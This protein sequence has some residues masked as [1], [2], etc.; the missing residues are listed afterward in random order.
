MRLPPRTPEH[1]GEVGALAEVDLVQPPQLAPGTDGDVGALLLLEQRLVD[2]L[3]SGQLLPATLKREEEE[4]AVR[5]LLGTGY[6]HHAHLLPGTPHA[7][8]EH[9]VELVRVGGTG[10]AFPLFGYQAR[11]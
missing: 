8:V 5:W 11:H 3:G 1:A 4:E 7:R 9:F 10:R 2:V 6:Y